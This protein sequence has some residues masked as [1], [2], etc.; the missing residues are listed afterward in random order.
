MLRPLCDALSAAMVR[1]AGPGNYV[2][3]NGLVLRVRN[4][5]SRQW[6]Q[7][8]TIHGR[9]VGVGLDSAQLV[10]VGDARKV[11]TEN[12]TIARTGGAP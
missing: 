3:G 2:D 1:S 11:A 5:G 7:R 12:R 6:V 8:L 9:R 4:S 10:R